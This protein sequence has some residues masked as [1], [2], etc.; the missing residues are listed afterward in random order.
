MARLI[1]AWLGLAV[2][3]EGEAP[4][5]SATAFTPTV[6]DRFPGGGKDCDGASGEGDGA[7]GVA[8]SSNAQEGL[9][10]VR[11]DVGVRRR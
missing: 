9:S 11:H 7:I 6:E 10:E 1:W 4:E 8:E 5:L 2:R 3:T